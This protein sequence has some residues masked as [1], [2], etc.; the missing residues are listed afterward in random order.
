MRGPPRMRH[1]LTSAQLHL[2]QD[3]PCMVHLGGK[4]RRLSSGSGA[5]WWRYHMLTAGVLL[6][7]GRRT[8]SSGGCGAAQARCITRSLASRAAGVAYCGTDYAPPASASFWPCWRAAIRQLPSGLKG[9]RQ[10]SRRL[11]AGARAPPHPPLRPPLSRAQRGQPR[12]SG[13]V[14]LWRGACGRKHAGG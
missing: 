6:G 8:C 2:H 9:D 11:W 12:A 1:A 14:G 10:W 3:G 4:R 5:G 13:R 7:S